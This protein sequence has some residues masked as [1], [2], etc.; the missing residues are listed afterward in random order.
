MDPMKIVLHSVHNKVLCEI[1]L[2]YSNPS[3][4]EIVRT[5]KIDHVHVVVGNRYKK[6]HVSIVTKYPIRGKRPGGI[7]VKRPRWKRFQFA[8]L[9]VEKG[10]S[11]RFVN[12]YL[13]KTGPGA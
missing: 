8:S 4:G 13:D 2:T 10:D 6:V 12:T 1:D 9:Y 11:I 5:G 7:M 3:I